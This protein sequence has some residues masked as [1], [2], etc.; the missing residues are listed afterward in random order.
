MEGVLPSHHSLHHVH[1]RQMV[2]LFSLPCERRSANRQQNL[3][4]NR[5]PFFRI[6]AGEVDAAAEATPAACPLICFR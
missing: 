6:D 4:S 2:L 3:P 5:L 1:A